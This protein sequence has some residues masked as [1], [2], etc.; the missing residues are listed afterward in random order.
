MSEAKSKMARV[1]AAAQEP[2]S[3][4]KKRKRNQRLAKEADAKAAA[5]AKAAAAKKQE[6]F[7][8]AEKYVAEYREAERERISSK[9]KAKLAGDLYMGAE[10]KL[11]LVV[12]I[13]GINRMDPR[14]KK[15]LQLFRLRQIQNATFIRVNKATLNMLKK[16]EPYVTYG[17]PNLKTIRELIYKR[18][19]AKVNGQRLPLSDNKV[20][21]DNL[22]QY[23]I[24]CIEDL[25]H[26]IVTVGPNFKAA[27]KFLWP[28]KLSSPL[29]GYR[30]KRKHFV[31]G[32]D[33][34]NREE[35]IN[36]FVRSMN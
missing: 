1:P 26:E 25:I 29:G 32:G 8:R 17:E 19:Y 27:N 31:E 3:L 33:A 2:E 9:R 18:G 28:F 10:S 36:A 15:V 11:L 20:I 16:I 30:A 14:V 35:Y 6:I 13:R 5:E 4:L 23:G 34:G 22:G 24:I 12:R 7:K 21:E